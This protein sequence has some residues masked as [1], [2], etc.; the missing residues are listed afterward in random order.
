MAG[1]A[2]ADNETGIGIGSG[3]RTGDE[4]VSLQDR[5]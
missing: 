2:D 3:V 4:V 5:A 1:A